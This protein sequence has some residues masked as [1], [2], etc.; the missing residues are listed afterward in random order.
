M[1]F[2]EEFTKALNTIKACAPCSLSGLAC[3]SA[4]LRSRGR[5][6]WRPPARCPTQR[7]DVWPCGPLTFLLDASR[8]PH[9]SCVPGVTGPAWPVTR[10]CGPV[11][12]PSSRSQRRRSRKGRRSARNQQASISFCHSC[13]GFCKI[14]H[15]AKHCEAFGWQPEKWNHGVDSGDA[16]MFARWLVW[17]PEGCL[18]CA[19]PTT[20]K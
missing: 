3:R 17:R 16:S 7:V 11:T 19:Y 10:P 14:C 4:Q 6:G 15:I 18:A 13:H 8:L 2:H 9:G 5:R 1:L 20:V 12:R